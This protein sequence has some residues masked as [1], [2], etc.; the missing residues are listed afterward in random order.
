MERL[1]G[2][3][4]TPLAQIILGLATSCAEDAW[5]KAGFLTDRGAGWTVGTVNAYSLAQATTTICR[6]VS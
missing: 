6:A 5:E 3:S 4:N 2:A 1:R